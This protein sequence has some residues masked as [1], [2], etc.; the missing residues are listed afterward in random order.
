MAVPQL[1]VALPFFYPYALD[2]PRYTW[3]FSEPSGFNGGAGSSFK[4]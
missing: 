1:I 2:H 3:L 4:R